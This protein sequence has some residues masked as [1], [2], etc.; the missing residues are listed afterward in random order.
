MIVFLI[1]SIEEIFVTTAVVFTKIGSSFITVIL[2]VVTM[3][4]LT[5]VP[6]MITLSFMARE[7][8]LMAEPSL[9]N[10]VLAVVLT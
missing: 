4:C 3:S 10:D 7:E 2:F 8:S 6:I 9:M 1:K 5:D